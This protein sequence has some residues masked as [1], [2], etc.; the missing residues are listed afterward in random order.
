[1]YAFR[2]WHWLYSDILLLSCFPNCLVFP[3]V[4][5]LFKFLPSFFSQ[6]WDFGVQHI[7]RGKD[8]SSRHFNFLLENVV[9]PGMGKFRKHILRLL[10]HQ[11]LKMI[12]WSSEDCWRDL[13]SVFHL[14][15]LTNWFNVSTLEHFVISDRCLTLCYLYKRCF[16]PLFCT[17]KSSWM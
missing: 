5:N 2:F 13:L 4:F 7:H 12:F 10:C 11:G 6:I 8:K 1:M 17:H 3:T 16:T 9:L 14:S 15:S